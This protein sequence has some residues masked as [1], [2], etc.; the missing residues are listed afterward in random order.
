VGERRSV[1][2]V[3][4]QQ[5]ESDA[6]S[7]VSQKRSTKGKAKAQSRVSVTASNAWPSF[8]LRMETQ[9]ANQVAAPAETRTPNLHRAKKSL[10]QSA[11]GRMATVATRRREETMFNK[12]TKQ[13]T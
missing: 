3:A 6:G 13:L 12:K 5:S 4:Q 11:D 10:I 8:Y 7:R 2:T 9:V 1:R